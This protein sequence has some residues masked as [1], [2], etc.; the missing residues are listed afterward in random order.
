M[1][2]W[3][4]LLAVLSTVYRVRHGY[5]CLAHVFVTTQFLFAVRFKR[6]LPEGVPDTDTKLILILIL[7][8]I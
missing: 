8:Q 7:I 6:T 4:E 5:P 2:L 3:V 1:S